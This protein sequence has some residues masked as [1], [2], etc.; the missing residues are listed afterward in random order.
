MIS[1]SV[2]GSLLFAIVVD[3]V[4]MGGVGDGD[5]SVG[6]VG[7]SD[8]VD[9]VGGV[10]GVKADDEDDEEDEDG[11]ADDEDAGVDEV[12]V[13]GVGLRLAERRI[14]CALSL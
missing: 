2:A 5:V 11:D 8:R 6:G 9:G 13:G 10:G 3:E 4:A 1:F 12:A 14:C 7:V